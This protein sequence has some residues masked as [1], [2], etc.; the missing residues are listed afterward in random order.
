M[1]TKQIAE[2]LANTRKG[3][4]FS[5][6]VRRAAKTFK[7]VTAH[8]VKTTTM[9]CQNA[10]YAARKAVR[11]AVEAGER[12]APVLPSYVTEVFTEG[13]VKFWRGKN[14][15]VYFPVPVTNAGTPT[16]EMDGAQVQKCDIE[17]LLLASEKSAPADKEDLADKGQ[18]PFIGVNIDNI[19]AIGA[20]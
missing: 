17:H 4:F 11:E 5:V 10:D 2:V 16:W 14:G 3:M 19:I 1:T 20:K 15:S 13:G 7:G 12:E 9:T 6:T 18:V 8:I